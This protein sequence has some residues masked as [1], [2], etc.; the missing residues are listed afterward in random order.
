MV[1]YFNTW[2]KEDGKP[3]QFKR[4]DLKQSN[5]RVRIIINIRNIYTAK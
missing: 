5:V 2:K 4:E 1:F 3:R